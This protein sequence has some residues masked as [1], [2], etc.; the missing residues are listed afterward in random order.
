MAAREDLED[1][2]SSDLPCSGVAEYLLE[3]V[4]QES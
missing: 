2:A 3:I 4:Q 1:L